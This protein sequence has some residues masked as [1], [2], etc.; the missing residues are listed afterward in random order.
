MTFN[1]KRG[2]QMRPTKFAVAIAALMMLS[3]APAALA[4]GPVK[5]ASDFGANPG[6]LVVATSGAP[7]VSG[8]DITFTAA[9]Q[10]VV[11]DA[12][13]AG[14]L[15]LS[16]L[17]AWSGAFKVQ[18]SDKPSTGFQDGSMTSAA[19]ASGTSITSDQQYFGNPAG[20]YVMITVTSLASGAITVTPM[21]HLQRFPIAATLSAVTVVAS[22]DKGGTLASSGVAQNAIASNPSRKAWC[23]QNDPA[24][25]EALNVRTD[26]NASGTTGTS[27]AAGQQTCNPPGMIT[28]GAISVFAATAG[29]RWLG[30]EFQ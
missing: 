18:W 20:R 30:Q 6:G 22:T 2:A 19:G 5:I 3:A 25:T 21:L 11:I 27:L 9:A 8:G 17:G 10:S 24:A 4:Q 23:I 7:V 1:L 26:G 14:G 13:G 28:T 29:H 12:A 16:A 15:S